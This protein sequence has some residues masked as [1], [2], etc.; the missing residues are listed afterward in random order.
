MSK[1]FEIPK[2]LSME[3]HENENVHYIATWIAAGKHGKHLNNAIDDLMTA[4][5]LAKTLKESL[6]ASHDSLGF[7][8]ASVVNEI[9]K[10][11]DKA[12]S[13]LDRHDTQH[14]NL[15]VAYFDL[16]AEGAAK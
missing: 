16:K 6:D 10:R 12:Y 2:V 15:F 8:A 5:D 3:R 7:R 13:R 9:I 11:I 4:T 1:K 14:R